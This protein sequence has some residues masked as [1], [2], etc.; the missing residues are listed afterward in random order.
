MSPTRAGQL[1]RGNR[2]AREKFGLPELPSKAIVQ[3]HTSTHLPMGNWC[4]PAWRP[5]VE[6]H[7]TG[8]V[9]EVMSRRPSSV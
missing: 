7:N 3:T 2:P 6:G 1:R 9:S 8:G 4:A 5:E